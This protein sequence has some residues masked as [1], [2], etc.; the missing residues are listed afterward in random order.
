M[1]RITVII[2]TEIPI[3]YMSLSVTE[4]HRN[5]RGRVPLFTGFTG[6]TSECNRVTMIIFGFFDIFSTFTGWTLV[7]DSKTYRLDFYYRVALRN[8]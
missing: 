5:D 3:H 2:M 4:R 6:C 1:Q 8:R 7:S